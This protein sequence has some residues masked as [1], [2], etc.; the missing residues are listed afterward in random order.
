MPTRDPRLKDK[1]WTSSLTEGT[2]HAAIVSTYL[3]RRHNRGVAVGCRAS[4]GRPT[5]CP[6]GGRRRMGCSQQLVLA[7]PRLGLSRQLP[8][9]DL[10]A[11]HGDRF[12]HFFI[13]WHQPG[14]RV[15]TPAGLLNWYFGL[16]RR[17]SLAS[18]W[19]ELGWLTRM[20]HQSVFA[21]AAL[22]L[23][24]TPRFHLPGLRGCATRSP[25]GRSVVGEA[26]L[27]PAKS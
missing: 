14:I 19:R 18:P 9:R 5:G 4:H 7:G 26:G 22:K 3:P 13:L 1:C 11:M 25:S 2:Q 23:R 12:G 21:F 8:V 10:P 16:R 6:Q 24:R 20:P 17:P 15:R 27:E